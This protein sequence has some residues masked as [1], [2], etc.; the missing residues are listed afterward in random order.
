MLELVDM[1]SSNVVLPW[2]IQLGSLIM[3]TK[4]NSNIVS[5][6]FD[7]FYSLG[8]KRLKLKSPKR[9]QSLLFTSFKLCSSDFTKEQRD[10]AT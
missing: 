5:I 2:N 7:V 3:G 1:W 4:P 10:L 6:K 8:C 9:K